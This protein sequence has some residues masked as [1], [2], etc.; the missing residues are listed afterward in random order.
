MNRPAQY[1]PLVS[2]IVA[3]ALLVFF[4]AN[5][6]DG[7]TQEDTSIPASMTGIVL[8][9]PT[10]QPL[11]E[12]TIRIGDVLTT[13]DEMGRFSLEFAA[14][15]FV[16]EVFAHL[17][18]TTIE[19]VRQDGL[20]AQPGEQIVRT[21]H[22]V[23]DAYAGEF[24]VIPDGIGVPLEHRTEGVPSLEPSID[25]LELWWSRL[26]LDERPSLEDLLHLELPD[27]LPETIR[28]GRIYPASC[29][30]VPDVV[31]VTEVDLDTYA[32]GVITAEIGLFRN[33]RI[34]GEA[35]S[36]ESQLETFKLFGIAA[37]SY[38]LWFWAREPD[39]E[40][41]L[42]DTA[43]NQRYD[44]GPYFDII[45]QAAQ[46]TSGMIF[47]NE[48]TTAEIDKYEYASSCGRCGTRPEHPDP[49][50][51][52]I[53][54]ETD[55][56]ACWGDW[57]GHNGCG[58]HE[59]ND[60]CPLDDANHRCLV[61][62]ICQWGSSERAADGETFQVMA[63]HYQPNL[64]VRDFDGLETNRLLGFVREGSIESGPNIVGATIT[65]DTGESSTT[66]A[67]G[68]FVFENVEPGL[69]VVDATADGFLPASRTVEVSAAGDTWGSLALGRDEA[70]DIVEPAA[71][72]GIPDA[73]LDLNQTAEPEITG[74]DTGQAG[75]APSSA[76]TVQTTTF[77]RFAVVG[78]EGLND[79]CGCRLVQSQSPAKRSSQQLILWILIGLCLFV[80]GRRLES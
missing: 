37:R 28:V 38:A 62:G 70:M 20:V 27:V 6:Q 56:V 40:Y 44:D 72:S 50:E 45:N 46:E 25:L 47:I 32:A 68:Q 51:Q 23:T 42:N 77:T 9:G 63:A 36:E 29:S 60:A 17:P 11:T 79:G 74:T 2:F 33:L 64:V 18:D 80:T 31:P 43:C 65:L 61:R 1:R 73:S 41:H 66:G 14:G 78:P 10:G 53:P 58:G 21:I 8:D 7:H 34:D 54:D 57:C 22:L 15:E 48:G 35:V 5:P 13:T 16:L 76:E 67:D 24:P 55:N 4:S 69:R 30:P 59:H 75:D 39:A 12:T 71:D 49:A 19:S 3:I 26:P 52:I